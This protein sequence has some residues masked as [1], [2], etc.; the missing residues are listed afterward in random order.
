MTKF[1]ANTGNKPLSRYCVKVRPPS[2]P[3]V[4]TP[5]GLAYSVSALIPDWVS[6]SP[7]SR[8]AVP[9]NLVPALKEAAANGKSLR[10]LARQTGVSHET[11][12]ATLRGSRAISE[13]GFHAQNIRKCYAEGERLSETASP[14]CSICGKTIVL[15]SKEA[16]HATSECIHKHGR[17]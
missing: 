2:G 4:N 13:K 5:L 16:K 12:R 11:I 10:A 3:L 7:V 17:A 14:T 1:G 8:R 15:S 6:P 9:R